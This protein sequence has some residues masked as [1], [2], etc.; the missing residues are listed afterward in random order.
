M[1]SG[2]LVRASVPDVIE[3][4]RARIAQCRRLADMIT[5][6]ETAALLRQMADDG[7][8]D[9]RRLETARRERE[10]RDR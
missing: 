3:N 9:V 1:N 10:E 6:R 4:I 5:D 2:R 7:E 8:R